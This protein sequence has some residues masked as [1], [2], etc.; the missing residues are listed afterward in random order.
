ME[1]KVQF[2]SDFQEAL[3]KNGDGRYD[4]LRNKSFFVREEGSGNK[5][6]LEYGS[7]RIDIT[8]DSLTSIAREMTKLCSSRKD[9]T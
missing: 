4:H 1:N 2:V 7:S 6:V 8:V 3:I 9:Q 5:T